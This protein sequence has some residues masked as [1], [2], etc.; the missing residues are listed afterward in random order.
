ML[1][2]KATERNYEIKVLDC[3]NLL[4][5]SLE[6]VSHFPTAQKIFLQC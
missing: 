1:D 2:C 6:G 3:L 4:F 5:F